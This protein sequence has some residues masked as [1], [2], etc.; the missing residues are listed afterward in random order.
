M[1]DELI[2][3]IGKEK[4]SE[5]MEKMKNIVVWS[6]KSCEGHVLGRKGSC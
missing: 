4:W 6:I 3:Q 5:V 2:E 1:M